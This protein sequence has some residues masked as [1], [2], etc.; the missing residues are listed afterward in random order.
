MS[1]DGYYNRK[2]TGGIASVSGNNSEVAYPAT[3][4]ERQAFCLKN[5]HDLA[6]VY[7]QD[8]GGGINR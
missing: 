6:A 8:Q 3:D 2:L 5:I 1:R 4:H 7:G